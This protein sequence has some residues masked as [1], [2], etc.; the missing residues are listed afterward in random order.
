[1][2]LKITSIEPKTSGSSREVH[3]HFNDGNVVKIGVCHEA[4]EQWG[5]PARN[6]WKTVD[7]ARECNDWLHGV[8]EFPKFNLK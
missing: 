8:G 1:M 4:W 3:V 5:A 7:I 6:R 2:E